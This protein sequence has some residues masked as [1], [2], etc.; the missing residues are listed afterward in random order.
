MTEPAVKVC[1]GL[2]VGGRLVGVF[3]GS[4]LVLMLVMAK[5]L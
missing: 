3:C 5:V 2:G 4:S 1:D